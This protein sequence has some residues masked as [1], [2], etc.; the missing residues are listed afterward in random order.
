[1]GA[2]EGRFPHGAVMDA[3]GAEG[4]ATPADDGAG[5]ASTA[6]LGPALVAL[7]A[8]LLELGLAFAARLSSAVGWCPLEGGAFGCGALLRPRVASLG[9]LD[10]ADVAVAGALVTLGLAAALLARPGRPAV[11]RAAALTTAAGAGFAVGLQALSWTAVA[12]LCS[13]C[14]ALAAAA[15][16]VAACLALAAR[17]AGVSPLGPALAFGLALALTAGLGAWRGAG[18]AAED[19][20]RRAAVEAAGGERGP[21][22]VLVASPGCPYCEGVRVDV[23]GDPAVLERLERTRGVEVVAP[24][25]PWVEDLGVRGVPTLVAVDGAGQPI[26]DP[27]EGYRTPAEGRRWLEGVLHGAETE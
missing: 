20:G 21:R 22:I 4:A 14:L 27:L 13:L 16:L 12:A 2:P 3:T 18:L 17:R 5:G 6:A 26:G 25:D 19:A 1:M 10:V 15:V 9:P 23:L 8:G 24:D 11:A 7:G